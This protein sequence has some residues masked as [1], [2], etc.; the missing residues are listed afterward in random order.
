MESKRNLFG[1]SI[2]FEDNHILL[3]SEISNYSGV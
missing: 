1:D 3:L 2:L